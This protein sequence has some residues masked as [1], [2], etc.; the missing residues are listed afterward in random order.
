MRTTRIHYFFTS[1]TP[2][3]IIGL[4]VC[5]MARS[6]GAESRA[7]RAASSKDPAVAEAFVCTEVRNGTPRG[8]A[9]V[10]SLRHGKLYCFTDFDHVE[11]ETVV[12]HTWFFKD[13]VVSQIKLTLK[14][15]RWSTYSSTTLRKN[16]RGPWR[17]E[18][19]DTNNSLLAT[20]PFSVV[21]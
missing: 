2:Y 6:Y 8:K 11:E 10:F 20:L 16:D 12:Q 14:P 17:I 21:D 4:V 9:V 13:S 15:P 7:V 1:A 5:C 19:T 3:L 18:I